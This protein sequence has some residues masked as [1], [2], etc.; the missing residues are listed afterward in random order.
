MGN[1]KDLQSAYAGRAVEAG[2][3]LAL[4]PV[5]ISREIT[6]FGN[7]AM[8]QQSPAPLVTTAPA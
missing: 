1:D 2:N 4:S 5:G 7:P 8:G 3:M 6:I